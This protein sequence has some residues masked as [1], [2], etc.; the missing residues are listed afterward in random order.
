MTP[1]LHP[2]LEY[3][4]SLDGCRAD[5]AVL[6]RL[7]LESGVTRRDLGEFV[8]FGPE[9]YQRNLVCESRWYE[10]VCLCWSPGQHTPIHDHSG[11]A[12]AFRVVEG[13]VFEQ[14]YE[15]DD[16]GVIRPTESRTVRQGLVCASIDADIHCVGNRQPSGED[17]V[18]L[19]VYSPPLRRF[20]TYEEGS[21][22]VDVMQFDPAPV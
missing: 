13:D 3:L 19:H 11:S 8:K 18:T 20:N 22:K 14:R 6:E 4:E 10:L 17:L 21:A 5:L 7:L 1:K 9:K 16:G 2:L 15:P 12:C